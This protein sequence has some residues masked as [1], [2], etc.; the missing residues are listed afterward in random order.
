M[1]IIKQ[2]ALGRAKVP[3]ALILLLHVI[4]IVQTEAALRQPGFIETNFLYHQMGPVA[5]TLFK[6]SVALVA[7]VWMVVAWKKVSK[8]VL[9]LLV[10]LLMIPPLYAVVHNFLL[11]LS[12]C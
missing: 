10:L 12:F 8:A 6:S 2:K 9:Y 11:L 5:F 4:D 3:I 7:S 1:A